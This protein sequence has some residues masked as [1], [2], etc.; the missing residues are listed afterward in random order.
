[1]NV[2]L[3]WNANTEPD[4]DHYRVYY[5]TSPGLYSVFDQIVAL[6][7][8]TLSG[9]KDGVPYYFAITAVDNSGNESGFSTELTKINRRLRRVRLN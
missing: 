7:T 2:T 3:R 6:T 1:M 9:L 8:V 4:L 5:G